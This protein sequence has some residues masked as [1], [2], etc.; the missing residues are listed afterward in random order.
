MK[1]ASPKSIRDNL[2]KLAKTEKLNFQAI[3]TRYLHER[4]IYRISVSNFADNFFLKGGALIYAIE[5]LHVR[6][7]MDIDLLAT[8]LSNDINSVKQV[9]TDICNIRYDDDCVR[10]DT[11]KIV[12]S[13]IRKEDKYNGIRVILN[14]SFDSIQ[15]RLQIDLGFSDIIVPAP[16]SLEY[17]VLFSELKK[18][19]IKAYSVETVI[20]EKFHA[21]ITLG[22]LNSRMKDFYD[23]YLLLSDEK[24]GIDIEIL[25]TAITG[26]FRNRNTEFADNSELFSE[27][28]YSNKNRLIMWNSFLRKIKSEPLDFEEVVKYIT[29][30]LSNIYY[31][32]NIQ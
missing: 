32:L 18:P 15:Q 14:T 24:V 12:V 22:N 25:K 11:E 19:K 9:F 26:T 31:N 30:R 1:I 2:M 5:G 8:H 16:V 4:L 10:F 7:T 3:V 6:P 23:V 29:S 20:A 13:E 27:D 17:P 28:F 21:M